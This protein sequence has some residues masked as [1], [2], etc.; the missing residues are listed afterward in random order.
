MQKVR[1]SLFAGLVPKDASAK[2]IDKAGQAQTTYN[3]NLLRS[4]FVDRFANPV[5]GTDSPWQNTDILHPDNSEWQRSLKVG[6]KV[7]GS[8][9]PCRVD[10]IMCCPE[11]IEPCSKCKQSKDEIC[12][13]CRVPSCKDW[14]IAF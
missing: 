9:L 5:H 13:D 8:P 4:K 12:G 3:L 7:R 1:D 10:R 6:G 2:A 11:D 14:E